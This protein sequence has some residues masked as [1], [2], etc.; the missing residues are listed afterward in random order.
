MMV[1]MVRTPAHVICQWHA[2]FQRLR[3]TLRARAVV[4]RTHDGY[5]GTN[6]RSRT[7]PVARAVSALVIPRG[8]RGKNTRLRA[9][10]VPRAVAAVTHT[11]D[12][13]HG[14]NTRLRTP[15]LARA[16]SALKNTLCAHARTHD[17]YHGKNARS[18]ALPMAR[19]VSALEKHSA[20]ARSRDPHACWLPW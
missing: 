4:T 7:P 20:S 16:V 9:P 8:D 12:G 15:P 2:Q 11:H 10:P 14:K 6:A 18:R 17:G 1:T 5:H 13:D 3:N 19:A